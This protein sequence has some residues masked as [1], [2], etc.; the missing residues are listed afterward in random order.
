M[1]SVRSFAK[2]PVVIFIASSIADTEACM[3]W[4]VLRARGV[5][6]GGDGGDASPQNL[7]W[8]GR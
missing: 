1:S 8:G 4:T 7:E 2:L 6:S 5:N 3:D